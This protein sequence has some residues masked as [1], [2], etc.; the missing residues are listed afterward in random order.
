VND[1]NPNPKPGLYRLCYI[2]EA[3]NPL[4]DAQL[5]T[6]L[7]K[8]RINNRD[9]GVT[10][11]LLYERDHFLQMIEGPARNIIQLYSTIRKDPRHHEVTTISEGDTDS[12]QFGHWT[13]AHF[14]IERGDSGQEEGYLRLMTSFRSADQMQRE[15]GFLEQYLGQLRDLLPAPDDLP[16]PASDDP[17]T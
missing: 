16:S 8:A 3:T 12:R 7:E 5:N 17:L 10:G 15:A 1:P 11:I 13:M 6:L 4:T 14:R 2:S 9:L